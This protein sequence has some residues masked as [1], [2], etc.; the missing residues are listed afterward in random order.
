MPASLVV[1]VWTRG[2]NALICRRGQ[3]YLSM[4]SVNLFP[5]SLPLSKTKFIVIFQAPYLL[6]LVTRTLFRFAAIQINEAVGEKNLKD[7]EDKRCGSSRITSIHI[8]LIMFLNIRE[9]RLH[10]L[11]AQY[12][13]E[14]VFKLEVNIK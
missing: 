13:L 4:A 1:F 9:L 6:N 10:V 3:I 8:F 5:I 2:E 14:V 12:G 11:S 7:L